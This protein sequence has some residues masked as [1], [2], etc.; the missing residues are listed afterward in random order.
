[1]NRS[2]QHH[3]LTPLFYPR[4]IAVIGASRHRGKIGYEIVR[5]LLD[6]G[7]QGK[8]F[9]VNPTADVVHSIKAYP[10]VLDVPDPVDLAVVVVPKEQVLDVVDQ[11]G[12][13]GVRGL[14]VITAGFR[15]TGPE[16]AERERQLV[17]RV[18]QY[19]M[20]MIGPNCM[21]VINTDPCVSMNATFAYERPLPGSIGFISQ[22]GALGAAILSLSRHLNLGFSMFASIGNKAN[23]SSN[24]LLE[25]WDSDERTKVILLYLEDFGNPRRFAEIARRVMRR[26]PVIAVKSG[27]TLAG[28]RAAL[29]HTGS[30][31]GTDVAVDA[32]LE[33]CGVIRA[34]S[35]GDMFDMAM[36]F[37]SQPLPRGR[38][39]A[40]LTNAGGPGIL[41]AD[42]C[43][44]L[45]LEIAEL[46][47]ST[48]TALRSFLPREAS[49]ENPV[50]M[51]ASATT[52]MY[53]RAMRVLL[54][55][56]E[57]DSLMVVNVPPI[58]QDPFQVAVEISQIA[59]AYD[60][61]VVGCFM[62][63]EAIF[64]E[65]QR[66]E[67]E[68]I[69]LYPFPES[70][71]RALWGLTRYAELRSRPERAPLPTIQADVA[72]AEAIL[73]AAWQAGRTVLTAAEAQAVLSCYGIAFPPGRVV[74]SLEAA[75]L[76]CRE[77][78]YP[79]VMKMVAPG[80]VHKS[81]VGGV[82]VD[83]RNDG[84]A[85]DAYMELVRRAEGAGIALEGVYVQAM[86]RGVEVI[87]GV[88][89]DPMFGHVLM[90][91]LGGVYV[92]VLKDVAFRVLPVYRD[93]IREMIRS[94]KA[95][96][97]LAGVR[98]GRPV[99]L[100]TLE[101]A[102][103]RLARLVTDFPGIRE[104]EVNPFLVGGPGE[105]AWAVDARLILGNAPRVVVG[106]PLEP[107]VTA[108]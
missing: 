14:V 100:A 105:P 60:K 79:V 101:D 15:E 58:M 5:N 59:R 6:F 50:D 25:Y 23:V 32:L 28:S 104:V 41:A 44:G 86:A 76:A 40:I 74:R 2:S 8:V 87:L 11:C 94:I 19:G 52:E 71:A 39:V 30:V 17:Q 38:R 62:G 33:Q 75:V 65:L 108:V 106:K 64:R 43:V 47:S 77:I 63:V 96:P 9:P 88:A 107:A 78:G 89:T 72:Q 18:R 92:E 45:G 61:P 1:M 35:I 7:F 70:A 16:G 10:T 36:A 93:D 54:E 67:V 83:V 69:P 29:S 13:K 98:G 12:R 26:K 66:R 57:V 53:G 31:A 84:E 4:S 81:D 20:R 103:V 55:A 80:L 22:S 97:I 24:D 42:A 91:G 82:I 49:V 68:L 102:L 90:F 37:V 73:E 46:S 27:R 95:Y 3:E 56:E 85:V 48:K 99:D 51:I 34:L 21:G